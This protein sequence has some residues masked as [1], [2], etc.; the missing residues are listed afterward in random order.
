MEE[1]IGVEHD[2]T[3]AEPI[4]GEPQRVQAVGRCETRVADDLHLTAADPLHF[5]GAV[6]GDD[7]DCGDAALA[8]RGQLSLDERVSADP[9]EAFGMVARHALQPPAAPRREDEAPHARSDA[10]ATSGG[11][12]LHIKTSEIQNRRSAGLTPK[13]RKVSA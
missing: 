8:E 3:A 12:L 7:G 5:G 10:V 13:R 4:A 11:L 1:H 2:A 9:G 6:T